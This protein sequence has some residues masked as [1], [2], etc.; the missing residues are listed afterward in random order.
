MIYNLLSPKFQD[1]A[2]E[3]KLKKQNLSAL[4][5][6]F[7]IPSVYNKIGHATHIAGCSEG[8]YHVGSE[9]STMTLLE[10]THI[11]TFRD[12]RDTKSKNVRL[13]AYLTQVSV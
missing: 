7:R 12:K 9:R 2:A 8:P 13:E 3:H 11:R 6:S 1:D 4:M 10:E 5:V